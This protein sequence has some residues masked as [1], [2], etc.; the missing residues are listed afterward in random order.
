MLKILFYG[1]PISYLIFLVAQAIYFGNISDSFFSK[2]IAFRINV[3]MIT[4]LLVVSYLYRASRG[5][6]TQRMKTGLYVCMIGIL[7]G[8]II[9]YQ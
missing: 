5:E 1:I 7:I 4:L 3:I 9:F 2:E 8:I 6:L